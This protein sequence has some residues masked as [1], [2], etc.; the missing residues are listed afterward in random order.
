[1]GKTVNSSRSR[2][3]S[4]AAAAPQ[5]PAPARS[6]AVRGNTTA[7]AALPVPSWGGWM[8]MREHLLHLQR[9]LCHPAL[10]TAAAPAGTAQ[11]CS[12]AAS[13]GDTAAGDRHSGWVPHTLL[14]TC[15]ASPS[16][17]M[18]SP[19]AAAS[20]GTAGGAS[21]W[22]VSG[23]R[24]CPMA[25]MEMSA[26]PAQGRSSAPSLPAPSWLGRGWW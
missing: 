12:G 22:F 17:K 3:C 2:P 7:E 26:C 14:G 9:T 4:P 5:V 25:V 24:P 19:C 20:L 18:V 13:G 11:L 10:P 15:K 23:S 1:M 21:P 16:S 6:T 8:L